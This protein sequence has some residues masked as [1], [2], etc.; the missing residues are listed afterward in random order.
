MLS[1]E[2]N[3]KMPNSKV[4]LDSN[5][6]YRIHSKKI[7]MLSTESNEKMPN[8]KVGLDSNTPYRIHSKNWTYFTN[9][10]GGER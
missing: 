4:G 7:F 8:S 1:T 5:T 10:N 9:I 3:E 2:S 6:P